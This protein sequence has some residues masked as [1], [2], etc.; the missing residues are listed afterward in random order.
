MART[1]LMVGTRKG[2]WIGTSDEARTVVGVDGPHFPMEEVYSVLIDR[3]GDTPRLFAGASSSWLG[4]QVWRSDDLGAS[5]QETP[6][7]AIRFP[8][9]A[10]LPDGSPA[11]LARVWQL[12]A[13]RRG[14]C[15]VGGHRAGRDLPLDRPRRDLRPG[16]RAVGPPA[17]PGVERGLRRPG[18]PHDPAAPDGRR[19]GARRDL[20][21]RRLPHLR[22][23]R[24]VDGV[25]HRGQGRVLP[26]RAQLPGVRPVR[27][28]GGPR[29]DR[30]RTGSSSRTTAASTAPTTAAP[31]GTTSPPACPR[32]SASR[33]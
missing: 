6:N 14:R 17:P 10:T 13:R 9:D 18:V 26:R 7:G 21:R 4:P 24:L 16:A 28:Q 1:L 12:V 20:H 23:R 27:P 8:E 2:L 29:R 31:P 3:R 32:S 5:W 15:R 22:R 30:A 19:L 11:T 33:W 25:Q